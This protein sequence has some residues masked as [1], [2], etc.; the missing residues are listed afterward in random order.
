MSRRLRL[1]VLVPSSNTAL[2]PLTQAII[3][4]INSQLG[5]HITVHFSRFA[6]TTISLAPSALGQF[7]LGPVLAAADLLAHAQVDIIGWSGT[8][9]GWLGFDK[10]VTLCEEIEKKTGTKATTSV[11]A[12]NKALEMWD[13]TKLGLVTPY[14]EDVQAAIVENYKAI[15]V[16]IEEE[17]ERHLSVQKSNDIADIYRRGH[18]GRSGGRSRCCQCGFCDD[19]LYESYCCPTGGFLGKEA[20]YTG[21]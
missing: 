9:A 13:V 6:V 16:E 10:D 14:V 19:I 8:A 1:G 12:L 17:M 21:F 18:F 7:E 5:H 15:G 11:L 2:E 20:W 4:Q 3:S